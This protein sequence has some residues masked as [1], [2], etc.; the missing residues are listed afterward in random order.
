MRDS[1]SRSLPGQLV[2]ALNF[3][4]ETAGKEISAEGTSDDREPKRRVLIVDD[5]PIFGLGL[6]V[7]FSE[8]PRL[9]LCVDVESEL[10]ALQGLREHKPDLVLLDLSLRRANGIEWAAH[11]E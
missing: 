1:G 3:L 11:Q 4:S 9:Q 10:T 8:H 2:Q 6:A 7:L 5:H